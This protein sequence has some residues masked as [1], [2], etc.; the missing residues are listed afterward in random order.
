[1]TRVAY[2]DPHPAPT[3]PR[4]SPLHHMAEIAPTGDVAVTLREHAFRDHLN[5]RGEPGVLASA[6]ESVTGLALPLEPQQVVFGDGTSLQWLSPDEWL[7]IVPGGEGFRL[8]RELR[9]ALGDAHFSIVDVSGGQTLLS[10]EGEE[11]ISVLMKSTVYDV[12]PRHFPVGKG[13]TSVFAKANAIIRRVDDT[14]WE[15][16]VRRS[17]ADYCLRW[18]L[19]AGEEFGIAFQRAEHE[20][21]AR[22]AA[23]AGEAEM[24]T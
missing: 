21:D 20:V 5:L 13:V 4:Q 15:L 3:V 2:F 18:L 16:V 14:R 7:L 6:V 8:Q 22:E 11:A 12:D 24:T 17:F 19:D 23:P 10:L 9:K 1:M